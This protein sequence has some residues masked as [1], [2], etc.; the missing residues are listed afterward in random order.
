[1]RAITAPL[2]APALVEASL[3]DLAGSE[4]RLFVNGHRGIV[5]LGA[6][7]TFPIDRAVIE[8][9]TIEHIDLRSPDAR[10]GP[11]SGPI[12]LGT[13]DF[14][15][16]APATVTVP[17]V[18]IAD[19][20]HGNRR[21]IVMDDSE[22]ELRDVIDN[23]LNQVVVHSAPSATSGT[24]RVEP[25]LDVDHYLA[26]VSAARDAVRAGHLDKAVIARPVSVI[27]NRPM[28]VHAIARRLESSFGSTYRF[29][30]DGFIGASPELLVEVDGDTVRSRPLAGTTRTTGDPDLDAELAAALMASEKNRI[31]HGAAIE[32]VRE[33]LLPHCSYLDW[34]PEPSIVK[35]ANVQHLGSMAEGML[36]EP[37]ASV[38]ELLRALQPTPAVGGHP[39]DVALEL[40]ATHEGFERG[41]YGGAVGWVDGHGNGT[42]AVSLR[43]AEF[44]PDRL[45]ARLVAGGGIVA[46]SDPVAELAETQA[47]LQAMLG[48]IIR[49]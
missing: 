29:S 37:A 10:H 23:A 20:G 47:K 43:C 18:T 21:V 1:M 39:R 40:I 9:S 22:A 34:T 2:T 16:A 4:G 26:A 31:E 28:N 46:D 38:V 33:T 49:P 44:S 8:L 6:S 14:L 11:G 27:A 19:D 5:G 30:R 25:M 15:P 13:I 41:R 36:S 3:V 17:T 45:T 24:Y 42:W 7:L 32:M 35:V 12:G 48:A